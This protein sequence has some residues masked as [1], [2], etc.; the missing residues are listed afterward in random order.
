[1]TQLPTP[2]PYTPGL[3]HDAYDVCLDL[4]RRSMN[5]QPPKSGPSALV[6]A[7]FLGY[8]ILEAPTDVGRLNFANELMTDSKDAAL[9]GLA[10]FYIDHFVRC[11]KAM[12]RR[13]P[14]PSDPPTRASTDERQDSLREQP[15][16]DV[17]NHQVAKQKALIRD[18]YRCVLT[19]HYDR[20][21]YLKI[22]SVKE[23]VDSD[24]CTVVVTRATQI[25]PE[26]INAGFSGEKE[27][28]KDEYSP[29]IWAALERFGQA[30]LPREL[31]GADIHRLENIITM[32]MNKQV[33]FDSLQFWLEPTDTPNHYKLNAALP[34]YLQDV[35]SFVTLSSSDPE[36]PLPS[37]H[38]LR[39]HATCA[40]VAHFS[41]ADKYVDSVLTDLE[42][43]GVLAADGTS[44][45]ALRYALSRLAIPVR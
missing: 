4:E 23:E 38:Y 3:C 5:V 43:L 22:P 1:M 24:G 33:L 6:C 35:P 28:V 7:R 30:F 14:A 13:T 27:G 39:I 25:L 36:L 31:E 20:E 9:C 19:G 40:R 44:A 34:R 12:K 26:A 17:Q 10:K 37:P 41:G 15:T 21:A 2:N 45:D 11:F 42:Q 8:M 29:S 16:V 32:D 18:G